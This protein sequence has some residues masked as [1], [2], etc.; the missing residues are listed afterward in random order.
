MKIGW[1]L[2]EHRMLKKAGISHSLFID[3]FSSTYRKNKYREWNALGVREAEK[4]GIMFSKET[5]PQSLIEIFFEGIYDFADFY[6]NKGDVVIDVGAGYGDSA[7]W[8]WKK[9]GAD[10]Y[11]YEVLPQ[12]YKVLVENIRLNNASVN[13]FNLAIGDGNRTSGYL[14]ASGNMLQIAHDTQEGND[15][16]TTKIDSLNIPEPAVIKI[17]VEGFELKV[18]HGAEKIIE[19][20]RPR[21]IIETHSIELREECHAFLGKHEYILKQVGRTVK[22]KHSWM[23]EVTNLFYSPG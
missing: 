15:F 4:I 20:H 6:P 7:L 13:V 11:A 16:L 3:A 21:I 14:P 8:W 19:T 12:V 9:F 10:V 18:L 2:D 23:D 5:P 22:P 17:D 1:K